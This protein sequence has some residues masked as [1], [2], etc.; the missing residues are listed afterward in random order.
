MR[1]IV[2][3]EGWVGQCVVIFYS[4]TPGY[5]PG[6]KFINVRYSAAKVPGCGGEGGGRYIIPGAHVGVV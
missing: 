1:T 4:N 6:G 2:D 5:T 3:F